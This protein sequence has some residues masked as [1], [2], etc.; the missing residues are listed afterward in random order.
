MLKATFTIEGTSPV[1][2]GKKV[3]ESKSDRETNE[4]HEERTWAQKVHQ[5]S[6]GSLFWPAYGVKNGLESGAKWLNIKIPGEGKATFTKRFRCGVSVQE[7][8]LLSNG[9][10]NKAT[11]EC[12]EPIPLFVPSDGKKG[13]G[14]R[15]TRIFPTLH[16]WGGTGSALIF[17]DKI[18]E[19]IFERVLKAL[20]QF[21][22]FGSMRVENGGSNGRF[23]IVELDFE[24]LEI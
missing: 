17:D 20:G 9:T 5:N 8:I 22:G 2:F 1:M 23:N 15:V 10:S 11:L 18:S 19:S 12:V 13:S 7:N 3:A 24:E 21:V 16:E 14:K 6:D 4:Q